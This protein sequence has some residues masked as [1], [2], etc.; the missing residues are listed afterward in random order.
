MT[1]NV[2]HRLFVRFA[3]LSLSFL[4]VAYIAVEQ[5]MMFNIRKGLEQQYGDNYAILSL[6]M[7]GRAAEKPS[8]F[9]MLMLVYE[10]NFTDQF[11]P[12]GSGGFTGKKYYLTLLVSN[13]RIVQ[14]CN[15]SF[16]MFKLDFDTATNA[17]DTIDNLSEKDA[18]LYG[19]TERS[20]EKR[21]GLWFSSDKLNNE[22][23]SY[24]YRELKSSF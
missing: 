23:F 19:F 10:Y 15:W 18:V 21:L 12:E 14:S 16:R 22:K 9:R 6:H 3:V 13:N 7:G 17:W 1:R 20:R 11:R 4:L 8:L 5:V 24:Y 2:K